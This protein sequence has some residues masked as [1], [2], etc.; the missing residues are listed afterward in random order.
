[1]SLDVVCGAV[2]IS[3]GT[4]R[5]AGATP[6]FRCKRSNPLISPPQHPKQHQNALRAFW[7]PIL[8]TRGTYNS[9]QHVLPYWTC[10]RAPT[11]EGQWATV[12]Q[13]PLVLHEAY[14]RTATTG[15]MMDR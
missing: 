1:M 5:L 14:M 6:R 7:R 12:E 9:F 10:R 2:G 8:P 11:R 3:R 4:T 13:P 15:W